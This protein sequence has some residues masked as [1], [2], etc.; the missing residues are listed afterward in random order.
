[1]STRQNVDLYS[2]PITCKPVYWEI[3]HDALCFWFWFCLALVCL[4]A[5]LITGL[6][7]TLTI[8]YPPALWFCAVQILITWLLTFAWINVTI[9][10]DPGLHLVPY[11]GRYT[12]VIWAFAT[13][14]LAWTSLPILLW[15][16]SLIRCF[17]SQN[18][19][20]LDLFCLVHH[21]LQTHCNH[22]GESVSEMLEPAHLIPTIIPQWNSHSHR[23][24]C[25]V[26]YNPAIALD[27]GTCFRPGF[28]PWRCS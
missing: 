24:A 11:T 28:G 15:P 5:I 8:N 17:W 4:Y 22:K 21:S 7:L 9:L 2:V 20:S 6:D 13:F 16:L 14:L 10:P 26:R 12:T 27:Q 1:M 3:V 25:Q 23:H 19:H 18:C